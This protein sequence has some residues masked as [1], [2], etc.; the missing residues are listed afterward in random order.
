[1]TCREIIEF[2]ME[3]LDDELPPAQ[4]AVFD[5]HMKVCPQCVCYLDS[6]KRTIEMGKTAFTCKGD[7][8]PDQVPEELIRAILAARKSE[9]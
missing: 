3:Y 8:V 6:Y 7:N 1:M 4:K 5:R 2:L 9:P